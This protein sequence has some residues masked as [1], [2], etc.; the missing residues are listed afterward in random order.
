[1]QQCMWFK[2]LKTFI[3]IAS[4]LTGVTVWAA[5][6][7]GPSSSDPIAVSPDDRFVW[8]ANPDSDSVSVINVQ[9]DVTIPDS[10]NSL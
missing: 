3:V 9:G 5:T 4:I 10:V 1:M 6:S 7:N 2:P 8:V